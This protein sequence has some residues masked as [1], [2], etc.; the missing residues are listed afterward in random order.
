MLARPEI[1]NELRNVKAAR[2]LK[3][4]LKQAVCKTIFTLSA[5]QILITPCPCL[6]GGDRERKRLAKIFGLRPDSSGSIR[7]TKLCFAVYST[8]RKKRPFAT[9][10]T[11]KSIFHLFTPSI[12]PVDARKR[13][14][15]LARLSGAV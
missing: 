1:E 10:F 14:W 7:R 12:R 8:P 9:K 4:F 13:R 2:K 3:G 11:K 15:M 6:F 5:R